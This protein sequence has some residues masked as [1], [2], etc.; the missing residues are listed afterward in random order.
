ML[1]RMIEQQRA[2]VLAIARAIVPHVTGDDVLNPHDFPPLVAS[3]EFQ[4]EDGIL[5]GYLSAQM[6]LRAH[7]RRGAG[8]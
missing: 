7:L 3:A 5:A 6:A 8:A 1:E 4:Y 2:K